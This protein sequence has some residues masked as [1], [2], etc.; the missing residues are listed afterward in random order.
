MLAPLRFSTGIQNKVLEA[1]AAGLPVVATPAVSDALGT[2]HGEHL[3]MGASAADLA[4]AVVAT[5][6]DPKAAAV[7]ARRAR[8]HVR[9][10]FTWI[11][12]VRRLE[13]LVAEASAR[14]GPAGPGGGGPKRGR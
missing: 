13:R 9:A 10:R 7:R 4:A 11:E 8:E 2:R 6:R 1:M 12:P 5:L 14:R 3:M